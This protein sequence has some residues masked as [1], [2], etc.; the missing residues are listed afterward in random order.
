NSHYKYNDQVSDLHNLMPVHHHANSNRNHMPFGQIA[1]AKKKAFKKCSK[2][3]I[4]EVSNDLILPHSDFTL[5]FEPADDVKGDVARAMF[6][7]SIRYNLRLDSTQEHF[8]KIWHKEDPVSEKE[9]QR[10]NKIQELQKTRNP[11]IDFPSWVDRVP[12]F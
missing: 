3:F 11:F 5:Y 8:L 12:N 10:N 6:Y 4:G 1:K 9:R 2:S 7:F